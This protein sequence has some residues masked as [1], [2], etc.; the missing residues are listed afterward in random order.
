MAGHNITGP[1]SIYQQG[2][3][4]YT[5]IELAGIGKVEEGFDGQTAWEM[6]ALQGP[7]IKQG[8]ERAAVIRASRMNLLS[9]WR[10]YYKE[11]RTLGEA[12]VDGKPAW[13]VELTPKE[14][15]PEIFLF[16][17]DSGL[18]VRIE[19]TIASAMGEIPIEVTMSDYRVVDGIKFPFAMTQKAMSQ[20]LA[21]HFEK[22]T[23]NVEM[24]ADRFNYPP[25]RRSATIPENRN[26]SPYTET[27]L[28]NVFSRCLTSWRVGSFS[29]RPRTQAE[30]SLRATVPYA[31]AEMGMAASWI[32]YLDSYRQLQ[33]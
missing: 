3:K 24:P 27:L 6:N 7:R 5:L 11:A 13:R 8:E 17:K 22:V 32:G 23:C 1:V 4:S 16:D 9:S 18:L 12:D 2:E 30:A 29:L 15:K 26:R 19:Q 28:C 25:S 21:M 10:D 31:M 14:G 33:R 20:V